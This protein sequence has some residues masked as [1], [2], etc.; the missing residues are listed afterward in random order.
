MDFD[1]YVERGWTPITPPELR[2]KGLPEFEILHDYDDGTELRLYDKRLLIRTDYADPGVNIAGLSL[3]QSCVGW[4]PLTQVLQDEEPFILFAG[5][6]E[7]ANLRFLRVNVEPL[8]FRLGP[9]FLEETIQTPEHFSDSIVVSPGARWSCGVSD[10]EGC[11]FWRVHFDSRTLRFGVPEFLNET[12]PRSDIHFVGDDGGVFLHALWPD[13]AIDD[14][15]DV[16]GYSSRY[17]SPTGSLTPVPLPNGVGQFVDIEYSPKQTSAGEPLAFSINVFTNELYVWRLLSTPT[18]FVSIANTPLPQNLVEFF[19]HTKC[20]PSSRLLEILMTTGLTT[21]GL[22][23]CDESELGIC[24]WI[25]EYLQH[26][27]DLSRVW[28][29][30]RGLARQT[31]DGRITQVR[32]RATTRYELRII[33][34]KTSLRNRT[35]HFLARSNLPLDNLPPEL[36]DLVRVFAQ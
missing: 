14:Y 31:C 11:A 17:W 9:A 1:G 7:T 19:K 23:S 35:A 3:P 27:S 36:L 15:S 13:V 12:F 4:K 32:R 10:G 34:S 22:I 25:E 30:R 18:R 6:D 2:V 28:I 33:R 29:C 16:L 26:N 21:T 20:A 5:V 8:E 24:A